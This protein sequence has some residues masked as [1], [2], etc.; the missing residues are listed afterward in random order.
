MGHIALVGMPG[1]ATKRRF[2]GFKAESQN[3]LALI[4]ISRLLLLVIL[5][6]VL[7]VS[8]II[9]YGLL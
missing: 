5:L 4:S 1:V 3:G 2:K 6:D 7:C 8:F 9:I